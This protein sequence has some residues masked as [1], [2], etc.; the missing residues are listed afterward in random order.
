MRRLYKK[1]IFMFWK[2]A[3]FVVPATTLFLA[4][5]PR[6]VIYKET[7]RPSMRFENFNAK[8]VAAETERLE[9]QLFQ[10]RT[11][12]AD[13]TDTTISEEKNLIDLFELAIHRSNTEP[14]YNKAY[15][16]AEA[17]YRMGTKDKLYY[18]N[19]GRML[20]NYFELTAL[21]D[22]LSMEVEEISE[23]KES[24]ESTSKK[25]SRKI[26]NLYAVV[27]E[28]KKTI[29][30]LNETIEKQKE[31]IEKLKKLDILMEK[32]RSTIE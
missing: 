21:K 24:L 26:N 23:N 19:W 4:C 1:F 18:L 13:T 29:E 5:T 6:Q 28:Q 30:E 32:E 2:R 20:K 14:D 15:E 16:Y 27:E 12:Q 3:W 31:T 10:I 22:S 7:P 17:L 25:R 9:V 8:Q 11:N